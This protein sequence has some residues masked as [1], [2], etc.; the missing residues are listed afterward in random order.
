MSRFRKSCRAGC[1]L[2]KKYVE[3]VV[4]VVVVVWKRI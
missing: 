1:E 4:V 2:P 3:M